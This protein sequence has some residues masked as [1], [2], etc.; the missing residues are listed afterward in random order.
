MVRK[1][2]RID[3]YIANAAPFA[4]PIL[5]HL[6]KIVHKGAPDAVETIKWSMPHFENKGI[7]CG[8]AAF[9]SHCAFG[10]RKRALIF[11]DGNTTDDAMGQ[12][13]RIAKI[14]D[15]PND[16]VLVIYVRKAVER[17]DAGV[18]LP[19]PAKPAAKKKAP[20]VVPD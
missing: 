4:R 18:K 16:E 9:K 2:P 6:R 8:M 7:L 1:D 11:G 20:V 3:A 15:L 19:K 5:K 12:F 17:N 10:F 14:S 13:G